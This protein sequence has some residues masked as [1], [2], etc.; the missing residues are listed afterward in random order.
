MADRVEGLLLSAGECRLLWPLLE[1]SLR[2][3]QTRGVATPQPVKEVAAEVG[4]IVVEANATRLVAA[5]ATVQAQRAQQ[6]AVSVVLTPKELAQ[7][8]GISTAWVRHLAPRLASPVR[9]GPVGRLYSPE[10]VAEMRA[11]LRK[12]SG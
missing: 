3:R 10:N 6:G 2:G 12:G 11:L 9:R 7:V 8:L 1:E 5:A 4:R